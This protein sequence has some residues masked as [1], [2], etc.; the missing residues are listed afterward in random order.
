MRCSSLFVCILTSVVYPY[1]G[2]FRVCRDKDEVKFA[3]C[4]WINCVLRTQWLCSKR[5]REME[6]R[7]GRFVME[8]KVC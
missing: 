4:K 3:Q 2:R 5:E 1:M 7:Q 8:R 6:R